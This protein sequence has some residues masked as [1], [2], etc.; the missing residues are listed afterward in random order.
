M[1]VVLSTAFV[2]RVEMAPGR[3]Q[4]SCAALLPLVEA[5]CWCCWR[6]LARLWPLLLPVGP[7][8]GWGRIY[9]E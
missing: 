6:Q 8:N 3:L 9:D 1:Q 4:Q 7:A 5:G 2:A